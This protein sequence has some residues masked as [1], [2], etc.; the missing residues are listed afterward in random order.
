VHADLTGE[1]WEDRELGRALGIGILLGVP[2]MFV[3]ATLLQ[4]LGD[5]TIWQAAGI[6]LLPAFF[7]GPY[8]GGLFLMA[9]TSNAHEAH[10]AL[11]PHH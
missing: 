7:T 4:V 8:L 5:L 6:A 10:G 11:H 2:L 3:I 9:H 1:E